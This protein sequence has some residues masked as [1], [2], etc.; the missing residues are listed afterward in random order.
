LTGGLVLRNKPD[1]LAARP[2]LISTVSALV[3]GKVTVVLGKKSGRQSVQFKVNELGLPTL[4]DAEI[5]VLL[6]R[7]KDHAEATAASV[8][9]ELF[10]QWVSEETASA[11]SP[12]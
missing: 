4:G 5:A 8:P 11:G 2:L 1:L 6:K 12:R 3:G 10:R 7:V 9:D